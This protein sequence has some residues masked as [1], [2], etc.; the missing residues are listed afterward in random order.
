MVEWI[1][2]VFLKKSKRLLKSPMFFFVINPFIVHIPGLLLSYGCTS[3]C[4]SEKPQKVGS[5][6]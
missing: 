2:P 5:A 1:K 4:F 6:A 3:A